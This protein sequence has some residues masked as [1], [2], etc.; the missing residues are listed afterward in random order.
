M[1][2]QQ[3]TNLIIIASVLIVWM[4]T[5]PSTIDK[6]LAKDVNQKPVVLFNMSE[7]ERDYNLEVD[8]VSNDTIF[9]SPKEIK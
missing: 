7:E 4:L 8:A 1:K 2:P 3:V 6:Q 9:V 5:K